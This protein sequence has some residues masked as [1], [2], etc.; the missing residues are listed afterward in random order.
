[1]ANPRREPAST[2][3]DQD[4]RCDRAAPSSWM[5]TYR[6][7]P[8]ARARNAP[9]ARAR[10]GL[11]TTCR[12]RSARRRSAPSN[13][14]EPQHGRRISRRA[15][16]RCRSPRWRCAARNRS[17]ARAASPISPGRARPARSRGPLRSCARRFRPRRGARATSL[18]TSLRTQFA[19]NSA[20]CGAGAEHRLA[21]LAR[22]PAFVV[23]ERQEPD[24]GAGGEQQAVP[25]EVAPAVLVDGALDR[26]EA[27]LRTSTTGTGGCPWPAR[28]GSP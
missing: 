3:G 13:Q 8:A 27:V 1:M 4:L 15:E 16:R 23:D 21:R 9:R 14:Q 6:I 10:I 25:G 2:P 20:R 28:S 26:R 24:R 22:H 5:I 18:A 12:R 19:S 7:D 17:R 11:P